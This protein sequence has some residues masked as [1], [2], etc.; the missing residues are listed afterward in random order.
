[1]T[2]LWHLTSQFASKI[3]L[4]VFN[5]TVSQDRMQK[6]KTKKTLELH[7][8]QK[9]VHVCSSHPNPQQ[10]DCPSSVLQMMT[11]K[12]WTGPKTENM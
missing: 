6:E 8:K 10:W 9:T 4:A 5:N 3:G 7:H 2:L 1:M 11:L 12:A